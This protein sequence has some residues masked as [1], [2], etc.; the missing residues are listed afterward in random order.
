MTDVQFNSLLDAAREAAPADRIGYRD[1]IAAY[2]TMT[3]VLDTCRSSS[4]CWKI[5]G[6]NSR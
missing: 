2:R 5:H 3:T 4:S 6:M 1:A